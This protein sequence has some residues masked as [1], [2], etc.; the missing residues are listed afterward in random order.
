MPVSFLWRLRSKGGKKFCNEDWRFFRADALQSADETKSSGLQRPASAT[1]WC[2]CQ[3]IM[4]LSLQICKLVC[5]SD[6]FSEFI[7]GRLSGT[8]VVWKRRTKVWYW[9]LDMRINASA[10]DSYYNWFS[11]VSDPGLRL[12]G[13]DDEAAAIGVV[14]MLA[15][16][17]SFLHTWRSCATPPWNHLT[18]KSTAGQFNLLMS[19]NENKESM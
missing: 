3:L 10:F 9:H 16:L 12:C 11:E 8:T 1:V 14:D 5:K 7:S 15:N 19:K 6:C 17:S 2:R 13:L 18:R 4:R